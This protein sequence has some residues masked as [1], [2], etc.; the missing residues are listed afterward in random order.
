MGCYTGKVDGVSGPLTTKAVRAFQTASGLPADG[1]YGSV[2]KAKLLA[3]DNA[4]RPRLFDD[5]P[6]RRPRR[7]RSP[8]TTAPTFPGVPTRL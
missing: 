3:A 6:R 8:L 7:R 5:P 4:G 1:V 2:T